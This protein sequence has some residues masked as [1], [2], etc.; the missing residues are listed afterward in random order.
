MFGQRGEA[1]LFN[2]L[3]DVQKR[4]LQ[5]TH[6]IFYLTRHLTGQDM[7]YSLEQQ[8]NYRYYQHISTILL[9]NNH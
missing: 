1:E 2:L 4:Y 9:L 7:P 5:L 8:N 3:S 6:T